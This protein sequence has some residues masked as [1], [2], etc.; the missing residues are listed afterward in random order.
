[1]IAERQVAAVGLI[2]KAPDGR[3]QRVA[4]VRRLEKT[5]ED[6]GMPIRGL[7]Q[8]YL[9]TD[10]RELRRG[11][12]EPTPQQLVLGRHD[13]QSLPALQGRLGLA[14]IAGEFLLG[15]VLPPRGLVSLL[16][17]DALLG[18][19]LRQASIERA[20]LLRQPVG[21][22]LRLGEKGRARIDDPRLLKTLFGGG[23]FLLSHSTAGV[24]LLPT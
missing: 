5:E 11:G 8:I 10:L 1:M 4:A 14:T 16:G 22:L 23:P 20:D 3:E 17:T 13:L 18:S 21:R 7:D 15:V 6:S 9:A 24:G 12:I 19:Q 2:A